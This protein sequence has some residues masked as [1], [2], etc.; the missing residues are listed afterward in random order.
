ML[1][2]AINR[3]K[4][5]RD[6]FDGGSQILDVPLQLQDVATW[7]GHVLPVAALADAALGR[8]A[9]ASAMRSTSLFERLAELK[10]AVVNDAGEMASAGWATIIAGTLDTA[11]P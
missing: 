11:K 6:L 9:T 7:T 10:P 1:Q 5:R 2:L 4:F 3:F 8:L